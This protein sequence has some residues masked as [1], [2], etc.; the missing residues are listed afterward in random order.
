M[1]AAHTDE[2]GAVAGWEERG[3]E[4][5]GFA[6][7]GSKVLFRLGAADP[8]PATATSTPTTPEEVK[9]ALREASQALSE[10]SRGISGPITT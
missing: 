3:P 4:W 9:K 2:A 6:T 8:S 7:D 1:W 5:R 10:V